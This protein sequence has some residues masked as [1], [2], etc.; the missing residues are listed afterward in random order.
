MIENNP[1]STQDLLD[2]VRRCEKDGISRKNLISY[3]ERLEP[4]EMI[5]DVIKKLT[6]K[7][8]P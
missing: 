6:G 8:D 1:V 2:F 7:I 3:I 5:E 4:F